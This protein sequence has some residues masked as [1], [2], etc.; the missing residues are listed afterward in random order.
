MLFKDKLD[1][2]ASHL[3]SADVEIDGAEDYEAFGDVLEGK[4]HAVDLVELVHQQMQT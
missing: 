4:M 3:S 1:C 2:R